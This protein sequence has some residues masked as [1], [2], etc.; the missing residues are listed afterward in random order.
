MPEGIQYLQRVSDEDERRAPA[1]APAVTP[2]AVGVS[3]RRKISREIIRCCGNLKGEAARNEQ[4]ENCSEEMVDFGFHSTDVSGIPGKTGSGGEDF[5]YRR[6]AE[7]QRKET[8]T[9]RETLRLCVSAVKFGRKSKSGR[10]PA[11]RR[12]KAA[13]FALHVL[14]I[15]LMRQPGTGVSPMSFGCA[16]RDAER[17]G[18]FFNGHP[19]EVAELD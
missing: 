11:G 14:G 1:R 3:N 4:R 7:T 5:S 8:I 17:F 12:G 16:S 15:D 10:R 9:L 6:G 2:D 13:A 19:D 18:C